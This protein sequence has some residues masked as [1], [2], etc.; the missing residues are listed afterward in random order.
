MTGACYAGWRNRRTHEKQLTYISGAAIASV[1]YSVIEAGAD[2]A[3]IPVPQELYDHPLLFLCISLLLCV[4][5]TVLLL[6][7]R[8]LQS[9]ERRYRSLFTDNGA[10]MLLI[11]PDSMRIMDANPAACAFYGWNPPDILNKRI[12][13]INTL[14]EPE[15]R[16]IILDIL[17][18]EKRRFLA[19]HRL[20]SGEERDVEVNS[21]PYLLEGRQY[22]LSI[23]HD[24]TGQVAA[25]TELAL[26]RQ[27]AEESLRQSTISMELIRS[28]TKQL[29]GEVKVG[30]DCGAKSTITFN[31]QD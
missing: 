30:N 23:I 21:M 25:E 14:P 7:R 29:D 2:T 5:I 3:D 13:D 20:A 4:I 1:F 6:S 12:T 9:S 19:R 31:R 10:I 11:E 15:I 18:Y 16:E 27:R 22:L 8:K 26:T 17:N 28:L 24:I